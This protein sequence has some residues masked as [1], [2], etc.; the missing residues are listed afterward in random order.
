[1]LLG[2]SRGELFQMTITP[3]NSLLQNYEKK[4]KLDQPI[5]QISCDLKK[6]FVLAGTASNKLYHL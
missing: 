6:G 3:N 1:L 4:I 2:T 5:N